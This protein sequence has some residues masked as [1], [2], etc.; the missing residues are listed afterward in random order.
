MIFIIK[1]FRFQIQ[2]QIQ[3]SD[4]D[5]ERRFFASENPWKNIFETHMIEI[6]ILF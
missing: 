2:I 6:S 1:E 4:S 3:I 5:S